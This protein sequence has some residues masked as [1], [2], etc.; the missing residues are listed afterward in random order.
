MNQGPIERLSTAILRNVCDSAAV[1][2]LALSTDFQ[3]LFMNPA[4]ESM[5]G[6]SESINERIA[7]LLA[8]NSWLETTVRAC[9]QS[10]NVLSVSEANLQIGPRSLTVRADLSPLLD[11][12]GGTSGVVVVISDLSHQQGARRSFAF[13]GEQTDLGLSPAGLAHEIKNPLTGIKGAAELLAA[14][15]TD[16]PRAQ[17]YCDLIFGGVARIADLVEQVLSLSGPQRLRLERVNV[18]MVLH[19]ALRT[20]GL[21]PTGP[22]GIALEQEFDPSLPEVMAD[23]AALERVFL[24]L[25]RN[26]A[27]AIKPPGRIRLRT[28]MET[29]FHTSSAGKRSR[30]MRV[31]VADSGRGMT[32]EE[33][34]Q[35]F[36][37]FFT[38]KPEGTGLGLVLSRQIVRLH[39]GKLSAT[40]AAD[41]GGMNFR[42]TLPL[43]EDNPER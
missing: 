30:F 26:A 8:S 25:V 32:D 10:G 19:Q 23:P 11:D 9:L 40:R 42:L 36:T 34:A 22:D 28:R 20:A 43:A 6:V 18:H 39:G 7:S 14:L 27:E 24:N 5:F 4:A 13:A 17:Q 38:T 35:L 1:G 37:P 15:F 41:L 3:L 31:E 12:G 29:E 2:I 16:N 33:I 21:F